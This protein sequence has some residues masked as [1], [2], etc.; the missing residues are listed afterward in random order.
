MLDYC[1]RRKNA[2]KYFLLN[3]LFISSCDFHEDFCVSRIESVSRRRGVVVASV[4]DDGTWAAAWV[5]GGDL[6]LYRARGA[7]FPLPQETQTQ[8]R[9]LGVRG[10]GVSGAAPSLEQRAQKEAADRRRSAME[11][12]AAL[13]QQKLSKLKWDFKKLTLR[14]DEIDGGRTLL[15]ELPLH[16]TITSALHQH[17]TSNMN[18]AATSV[19]NSH[20]L[21]RGCAAHFPQG[22][23]KKG[24][25]NCFVELTRGAV[26]EPRWFVYRDYPCTH[27]IANEELGCST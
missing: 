20:F 24:L 17:T 12:Q 25:K 5:A 3:R 16:P 21:V 1:S 10:V 9:H 11:N 19:V 4:S 6:Y 22:H 23:S 2:Q 18:Q 7:S 14:A 27:G 15:E 13:L 8:L 26:R